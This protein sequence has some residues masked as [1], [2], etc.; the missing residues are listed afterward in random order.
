MTE[1]DDPT[2]F[3]FDPLPIRSYEKKDE[4]VRMEITV[5]MNLNQRE[6]SRVGYTFLDYLSDV[7]GM[8]VLLI[9]AINYFLAFWNYHYFDN[10]LVTRLFK[11]EKSNKSEKRGKSYFNRSNFMMPTTL[12]NPKE[13]IQ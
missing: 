5:E 13:F 7:G 3:N 1:F 8:Q 4:S 12:Y 9:G 10:Y 2:V 6:I 11:I